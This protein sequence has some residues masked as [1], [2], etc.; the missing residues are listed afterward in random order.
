[1]NSD[2][3]ASETHTY[4]KPLFSEGLPMVSTGGS[5]IH[6]QFTVTTS[7]FNSKDGVT[8]AVAAAGV[9]AKRKAKLKRFPSSGEMTSNPLNTIEER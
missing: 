8:A 9:A 2:V 3:S 6:V 4:F 1:M 5:P 7:R